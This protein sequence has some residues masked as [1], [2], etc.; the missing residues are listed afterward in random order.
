MVAGADQLTGEQAARFQQVL[1]LSSSDPG[2]EGATAGVKELGGIMR[3]LGVKVTD[4]EMTSVLAMASR[5]GAAG[6][7]RSA[8]APGS[9]PAAPAD[10]VVATAAAR[11]PAE[12]VAEQLDISRP[13][14]R[15]MLDAGVIQPP[16]PAA[17][18]APAAPSAPASPPAAS[19][20]REVWSCAACTFDNPLGAMACGICT[21]PRPPD[22]DEDEEDEDEDDA[23]NGDGDEDEDEGDDADWVTDD[24]GG[25]QSEHSGDDTDDGS[26]VTEGEADHDH[27]TPAAMTA[28]K[29]LVDEVRSTAC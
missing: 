19:S 3:G 7:G 25:S 18:A 15:Q 11:D 6:A 28:P 21:T 8:P 23:G 14:A 1:E 16:P 10:P 20:G 29:S 24:E 17:A 22:V 13:D 9:T 12:V 26:W 27:P 5:F 2:G 4:I